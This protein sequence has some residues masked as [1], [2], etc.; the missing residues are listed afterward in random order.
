MKLKRT[1]T[2]ILALVMA[3]TFCLGTA[4]ATDTAELRASLT[5]SDYEAGIKAGTNSGEI[6]ISYDVTASKPADL[7]GVSSIVIYKSDGSRVTTITGSTSNG[8][9]SKSSSGHMGTYSYPAT[10]G[11]SYY[12]EVTVFATIGSITDS[13][14]ITTGTVKAP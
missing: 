11:V 9:I 10:S 3:L 6:R 12:A 7:V 4:F 1:S 8:L 14:P 5:L 13:R 2:L